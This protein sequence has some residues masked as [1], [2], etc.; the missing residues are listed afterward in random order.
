MSFLA[1]PTGQPGAGFDDIVSA[2]ISAND[3][4]A[5]GGNVGLSGNESV[6]LTNEHAGTLNSKK[7]IFGTVVVGGLDPGER[8][9]AKVVGHLGCLPGSSPTGNLQTGSSA[10]GSTAR[11][12]RS[13]RKPYP[14]SRSRTWP[15]TS[16]RGVDDDEG[17]F[18]S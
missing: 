16:V 6:S 9:I 5:G 15:P 4:A 18:A 8:V 3:N 17:G 10:A 11:R 12:S 7:A 13:A 1:E 2:S 14:S